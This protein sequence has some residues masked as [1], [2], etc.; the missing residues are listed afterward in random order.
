MIALSTVSSMLR[1]CCAI[2]SHLGNDLAWGAVTTLKCV[3]VDKG[4]LRGMQAS[5]IAVVDA[6][7]YA[8]RG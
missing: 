8:M 6:T 7:E 3:V 4:L 5:L 2:L 1:R